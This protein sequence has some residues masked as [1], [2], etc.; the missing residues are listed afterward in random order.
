M[1]KEKISSQEIIDLVSSKAMV[2]KRAAEE[3]LRVM[4]TTIEEAL[5]A[6]DVVKIKNFGTF[7]LQ[8]NE[9]RKSVNVQT[10]EDILLAGYHKVSFTPD[11]QLRDLVNEPFAHL[12]PVIIGGDFIKKVQSETDQPDPLRT[13]NDQATEIKDILAEINS[14]SKRKIKKEK[15]ADT[16]KTEVPEFVLE[17]EDEL[18]PQNLEIQP[19]SIVVESNEQIEPKSVNEMS[20]LEISNN[21]NSLEIVDN[22]SETV[23]ELKVIKPKRRKEWA[24]FLLVLILLVTGSF[25]AYF[26]IPPI[27]NSFDRDCN[28]I[29]SSILKK[30]ESISMTEMFNVISDWFVAKPIQHGPMIVI[31]PKDTTSMDTVVTKPKVDSLQILFDSPRVYSEYI[32]SERLDSGIRLTTMSKRYYGN[33]DFWVYIYEA[34]RE[35]IKNPNRISIGT[36]IILP[37]LD[38][39]LIDS[40]NPRCILKAKELHDIYIKN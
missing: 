5:L 30:S 26:F 20:D 15:E 34:N 18:P 23:P 38:K 33:K 11:A 6:G 13:L 31:I 4:I 2:S 27:K 10:G 22:K 8:W 35:R 9:P 40:S 1:S 19:E 25:G 32:C 29:K 14:L 24:L 36:L 21:Q 17:I 12:E 37:K 3:F 7:K 28:K 16:S 39:R